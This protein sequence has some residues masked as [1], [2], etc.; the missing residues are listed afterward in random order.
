M[1]YNYPSFFWVLERYYFIYSDLSNKYPTVR[2]WLK[3]VYCALAIIVLCSF[4]LDLYIAFS[5]FTISS[6]M[7]IYIRYIDPSF[8]RRHPVLYWFILIVSL[9]I[10][11]YSV[12]C[13]PYIVYVRNPRKKAG[14][15]PT[16]HKSKQNPGGPPH[17]NNTDPYMQQS[18]HDKKKSTSKKTTSKK[19]TEDHDKENEKKLKHREASARHREKM[20]NDKTVDE[21]GLTRLDK[22]KATT[23]RYYERVYDNTTVDENGL[24]PLDEYRAKHRINNSKY[25]NSPRGKANEAH[26]I[27]SRPSRYQ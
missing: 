19:A 3:E 17:N 8:S 7:I 15:K 9:L 24:T 26:K 23:A 16:K 13:L 18:S 21:N 20:K 1:S 14:G 4:N 22:S 2:L 12:L 27:L 5:A 10:I 11:F 6:L 25:R